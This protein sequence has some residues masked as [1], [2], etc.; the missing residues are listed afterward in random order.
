MKASTGWLDGS[1]VFLGCKKKIME[2]IIMEAALP[3]PQ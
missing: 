2:K 3:F 1:K